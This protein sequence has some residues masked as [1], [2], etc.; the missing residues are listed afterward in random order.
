HERVR[1]VYW[2]YAPLENL[3]NEELIRENSQGI[4]PAPGYP[5]CS[6]HTAQATIW[7][8]LVVD[9][10]PGMTLTESFAMWPGASASGRYFSHPH[11]KYY[12]VAPLPPHH[13]YA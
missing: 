12:A 8:L 7:E 3:S 11:S 5:A 13:V 2:G 6:E 10:H 1:T 4:R 9:K